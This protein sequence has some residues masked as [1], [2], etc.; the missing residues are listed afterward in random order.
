MLTG[1]DELSDKLVPRLFVCSERVDVAA[2]CFDDAAPSLSELDAL[3]TR[4]TDAVP[5]ALEC[6]VDF[7]QQTTNTSVVV[8]G[9]HLTRRRHV[10]VGLQ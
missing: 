2:A 3:V 6:S 4:K 10:V 5:Q 7:S 9:G 1:T 8:D